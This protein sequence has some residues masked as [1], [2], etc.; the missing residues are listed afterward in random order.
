MLISIRM[1][2]IGQLINQFN[3]MA[4]YKLKRKLY[5]VWDETDNIKRMKDSDIL[6]EKKRPTTNYGNIAVNAAG[7]AA[8]GLGAGA[9]IGGVKGAFRKNTGKGFFKRVG[10]G[11]SGGAKTGV[12]LG[13]LAAAGIAHHRGKKQAQEN[14]F[15]NNRLAYAKS[16]ALRRERKDWVTNMTQR[17]GY[18]Y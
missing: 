7:G 15:Y 3:K 4:K 14:R 6:A 10:R 9:V 12:V 13:G 17:D 11:I 16:Q 5:T 8:A 2:K 1:L 18:S